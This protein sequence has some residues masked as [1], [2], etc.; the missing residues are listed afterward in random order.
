MPSTIGDVVFSEPAGRPFALVQLC[1]ALLISSLYVYYAVLGNSTVGR[2]VLF[3]IAG[4]ALSGIAESLPKTRRRA[5]GILRV[6]AILVF[7]CLLA[8]ISVA[9]EAVMG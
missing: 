7:V 1:S 9:P 3:M 5:T 4:T 2:F 6:T 8:T